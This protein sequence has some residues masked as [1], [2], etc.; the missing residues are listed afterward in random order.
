MIRV[1]EGDIELI[2]LVLLLLLDLVGVDPDLL[3]YLPLLHL[4][5]SLPPRSTFSQ[6]RSRLTLW[7]PMVVVTFGLEKCL[8]LFPLILPSAYL[9]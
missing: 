5:L 7:H 8:F 1:V 2:Q 3:V 6:F 9:L 4:S